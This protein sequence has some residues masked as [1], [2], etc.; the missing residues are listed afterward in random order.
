MTTDRDALGAHAAVSMIAG[1][2]G[3]VLVDRVVAFLLAMVGSLAVIFVSELFRP[4]LQRRA[5]KIAGES[6]RP[7]EAP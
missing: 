2:T 7:P 3:A 4:W 1:I 6:I 5:R